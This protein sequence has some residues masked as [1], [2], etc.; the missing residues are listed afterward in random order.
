[1]HTYTLPMLQRPHLPQPHFIRFA[2]VVMMLSS[3]KPSFCIT[4][5]VYLI[6]MGGPQM[7]ATEFSPA[8]DFVV[9]QAKGDR[10]EIRSVRVYD[11]IGAEMPVRWGS[12][13]STGG[14]IQMDIRTCLPGLYT[15]HLFSDR[16]VRSAQ[17]IRK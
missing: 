8:G 4:G 10:G 3:V 15:V 16:N 14:M 5:R 7:M 17:F 1:M 9:L 12:A 11:A 13:G 6:M 2:S